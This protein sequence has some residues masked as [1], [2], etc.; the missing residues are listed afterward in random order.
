MKI[1]R[2]FVHIQQQ[3]QEATLYEDDRNHYY[4]SPKNN[5][6]T[7][8]ITILAKTKPKE[9][10]LHLDEWRADIGEPVANY[11][12]RESSI[13][14]KETHKLNENYLNMLE[15]REYFRLISYAHHRQFIPYLNR[16]DNIHGVELKLYSDK[17]Q[18]AGTADCIAQYDGKLSIIDYK[19][20]R[21]S[22]EKEWVYDYY[23]QT[24]AYSIMYET[25][26]GI[27]VK[28]AV[29]LVSSEKN[30]MQEFV[31]KTEDYRED[32][33][34]RLEQFKQLVTS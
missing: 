2:H 29:I 34:P 16:I 7:S 17:L 33:L 15:P 32:F 11:I 23:L 13:I 27:C 25:I 28:Q 1:P 22:Q 20:K 31:V 6:L 3:F 26:T 30:T 14:G 12:F 21:P 24:A 4:T 19:T 10:K 9:E 8:V 5:K 18:L